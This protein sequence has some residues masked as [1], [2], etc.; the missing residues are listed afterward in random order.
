MR[1]TALTEPALPARTPDEEP[2]VVQAPAG[3]EDPGVAA[4]PVTPRPAA[5]T[6][7]Q[8]P[9]PPSGLTEAAERE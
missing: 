2:A 5:A 7:P 8:K 6:G 3:M 9:Q 4:Q 1:I